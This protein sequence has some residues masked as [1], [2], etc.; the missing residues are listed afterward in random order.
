MG[1]HPFEITTYLLL[2]QT[3]NQ[4]P[5]PPYQSPA[6][7]ERDIAPWSTSHPSQRQSW[8]CWASALRRRSLSNQTRHVPRRAHIFRRELQ[9]VSASTAP[10]PALDSNSAVSA[11]ARQ[12]C[13]SLAP[14]LLWYS[15]PTK[16]ETLSTS[17][18]VASTSE[19]RP[20][21]S[22]HAEAAW[23]AQHWRQPHGRS[24]RSSRTQ[25]LVQTRTGR[26]TSWLAVSPTP[27]ISAWRFQAN[28]ALILLAVDPVRLREMMLGILY[29]AILSLVED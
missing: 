24:T 27:L 23:A 8:S 2:P 7:L 5:P 22:A 29:L 10:S 16:A 28:P 18:R 15:A 11:A 1:G 3:N 9:V 6:P 20:K 17:R 25:P 4:P 13:V 26:R 12:P 14:L 21:L 19:G